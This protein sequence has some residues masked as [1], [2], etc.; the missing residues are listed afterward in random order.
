[1]LNNA[2]QSKQ[3]RKSRRGLTFSFP[4]AG[5][6]SVGSH[7]D[8]V[9]EKA[10]RSIRIIPANAG[11]YK[12]SRKKNKNTWRSLVD[13]RNKEVLDAV[14]E[15]E[16]LY[17]H[18][19]DNQ[20]IVSDAQVQAGQAARKRSPVIIFPRADL[21][22]LRMASGLDDISVTSHLLENTQITLDECLADSQSPLSASTVQKDIVDVYT[23]VS[24]FSGAGILDWPFAQDPKF[25]IRYAIDYDAAACETYRKNIGMHIVHGD[26]HKAFTAAGYP[27]D[28]TVSDP[29]VII[30]GPSCKPFSNANRHTRLDDHP[31]SDLIVQ[32]MR[33]VKT[34]KPKVFAMENVPEVL[35]ACDG[36]YFDAIRET[37]KECGYELGANIVQ[38]SKVGGYTTR[39]RAIILG[40]RIGEVSFPSFELTS[41]VYTAGEALGKVTPAW[42]NYTD[43]TLQGEDT[44]RRM[45]FVPQ[46][47]NY[48]DIPEEY[49]TNSKNRHSCTYRRLAWNEPS[50]TIVNW[51]K[52]PLIHPLEDRTLTVAEAKALQG[53]PGDFQIYG[54]LGQKQQ[55][56]GNS[57]PVALGRY[58]KNAILALLQ[59]MSQCQARTPAII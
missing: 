16:Q 22:K 2:Y 27:L 18:I 46:G 39:K 58:I 37:A 33:I 8:Y 38:D 11:R 57:V 19:S 12:I 17:I 47:G 28:E 48:Q 44:K 43:V 26:I 55:Q 13:L 31:D 23:V 49:R 14:A 36:V 59:K 1:M 45:S 7:Y 32:Y 21:T 10:S 52:P 53:L 29:D 54:T 24:L 30:G 56:V 34:L 5:R 40:S 9:I 4:S 3:I 15:M 50:P 42:S 6:L 51:R 41:G 35:T 20:I 25:S